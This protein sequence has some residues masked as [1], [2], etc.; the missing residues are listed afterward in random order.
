MRKIITVLLFLVFVNQIQ[1]QNPGYFGSKNI[2]DFTANGQFN[3][4]NNFEKYFYRYVNTKL[5]KTKDNFDWGFRV[6]YSRVLKRNLAF[7]VECGYDYYTIQPY[8]IYNYDNNFKAN[9][10][11]WDVKALNIMPKL[12]FSNRGGLLPMGISHQVGLGVR[13]V[14]V[15]DREYHYVLNDYGNNI[16]SFSNAIVMPDSFR[17]KGVAKGLVVMYALNMRTPISKRLFLNYGLRYTLNFM[18][19]Q[20]DDTQGNNSQSLSM[21]QSEYQNLVRQRKQFSLVQASIGLSFAF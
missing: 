9:F 20:L 10:E 18:S 3:F 4:F 15:V 8:E 6:N 17:Y 14:K 2:V 13:L 19:R 21:T 11:N 12:E 7:G 16:S 5:V 1:A